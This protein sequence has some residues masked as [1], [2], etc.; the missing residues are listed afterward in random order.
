MG[1]SQAS[2]CTTRVTYY[3]WV[4][5]LPDWVSPRGHEL[6]VQLVKTTSAEISRC[7]YTLF[8]WHHP[9][10]WSCEQR[11][12]AQNLPKDWLHPW[13][14]WN[15]LN[16]IR[17]SVQFNSISSEP[18]GIVSALVVALVLKQ[19]SGTRTEAMYLHIRSGGKLFNLLLSWSYMK[20][21]LRTCLFADNT[22]LITHVST[23]AS[24]VGPLLYDLPGLGADRLP[25]EDQHSGTEC[26]RI[27]NHYHWSSSVELTWTYHHRKPFPSAERFGKTEKLLTHLT[28]KCGTIPGVH[29]EKSAG[30]SPTLYFNN[31]VYPL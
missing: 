20:C 10:V 24:S 12:H 7:Y 22:A 13:A 3:R 9:E 19:S 26:K 2:S 11:R 8:Y 5:F 4:G 15:P 14:G 31:Q 16:L 21:S 28:S 27:A 1:C 25:A 17:K 30:I 6:T 23:P 29:T 18:Y